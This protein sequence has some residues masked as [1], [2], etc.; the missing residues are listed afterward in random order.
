MMF[1]PSSVSLVRIQTS[2]S[3]V[4]SREI[5]SSAV[6][7]MTTSMMRS[8]LFFVTELMASGIDLARVFCVATTM[9]DRGSVT[10]TNLE[11]CKGTVGK[12]FACDSG[13]VEGI[14]GPTSH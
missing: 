1:T 8:P 4:V 5:P 12:H 3:H 7:R 10:A 11:I 9:C 2:S 6:M 14:T 13:K